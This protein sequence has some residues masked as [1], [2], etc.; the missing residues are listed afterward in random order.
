MP[1]TLQAFHMYFV[2]HSQKN[3][4]R[5]KVI[6]MKK[7]SCISKAWT[8][9]FSGDTQLEYS[10]LPATEG[11]WASGVTK[12]M[13]KALEALSL[14]FIVETPQKRTPFTGTGSDIYIPMSLCPPPSHCS[15]GAV[16]GT[17]RLAVP[18]PEPTSRLLWP[19]KESYYDPSAQCCSLKQL[20]VTVASLAGH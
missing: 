13:A 5:F 14:M 17:P 6:G 12:P 20:T 16:P 10:P 18:H 3:V 1:S 2:I 15:L 7:S 9:V 8:P 11:Y 19:N 4:C